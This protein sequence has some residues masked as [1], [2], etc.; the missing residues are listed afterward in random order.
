MDLE[1][2]AQEGIF[3]CHGVMGERTV[4]EKKE[5]NEGAKEREKSSF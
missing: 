4:P 2:K 3:L 5:K 1:S